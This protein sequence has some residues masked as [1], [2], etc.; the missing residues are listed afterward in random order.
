M[1]AIRKLIGVL[2]LAVFLGTS[3]PSTAYANLDGTEEG[4]D[5]AI[6]VDLFVLRPAGVVATAGGLVIFVGSLPITIATL[7]IKKTFYALVVNPARYTFVRK[8]GEDHLPE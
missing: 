1:K 5:I 8:I 7:S 2:S 3:M 6:V 4:D